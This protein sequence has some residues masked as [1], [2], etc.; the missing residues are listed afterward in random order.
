MKLLHAIFDRFFTVQAVNTII[1]GI[2]Y[3]E[4]EL[5]KS[6]EAT[7][8]YRV[9]FFIDDDNPWNYKNKLGN[10]EIRPLSDLRALCKKHQV[11]TIYFCNDKWTKRV[12]ALDLSN[13]KL[14]QG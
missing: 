11:S 4:F 6:L 3:P 8:N 9:I 12:E 7:K 5:S 10:G 13:I 2:D 14:I 1:L